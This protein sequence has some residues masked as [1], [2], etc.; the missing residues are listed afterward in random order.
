[1]DDDLGTAIFSASVLSV[2][3]GYGVCGA[4]GRDCYAVSGGAVASESIGYGARTG[5]ADA[6][7]DLVGAFVAGVAY[8]DD[9]VVGILGEEGGYAVHGGLGLVIER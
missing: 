8:D 5:E 9:V 2:V 4:G 7:I 6:H 1:M 3:G